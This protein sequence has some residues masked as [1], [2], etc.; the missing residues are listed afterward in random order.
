MSSLGAHAI[1]FVLSCTGS[2]MF[3][4]HMDHVF[5]TM[6]QMEDWWYILK[7][8]SY[9][10]AFSNSALN[11]IIYAGFNENFRSGKFKLFILSGF[12]LSGK[13]SSPFAF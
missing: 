4:L 7:F 6:F 12:F 10:L 2:I 5:F 3:F 11:P 13:V 8:V 1:L 9:T